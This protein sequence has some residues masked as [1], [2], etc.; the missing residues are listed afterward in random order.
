ML[1]YNNSNTKTVL[2]A[3]LTKLRSLI[4][5]GL[6]ITELQHYAEFQAIA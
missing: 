2:N 4:L 3:A 1:Y 6:I 5:I